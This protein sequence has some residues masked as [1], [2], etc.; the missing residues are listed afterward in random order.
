MVRTLSWRSVARTLFDGGVSSHM[1][2][3]IRSASRWS[4]DFIRQSIADRRCPR[5]T[6]RSAPDGDSVHD[7]QRQRPPARPRAERKRLTARG[8]KSR[9]LPPTCGSSVN[10]CS[11][12]R[13]ARMYRSYTL[14]TSR[15]PASEALLRTTTTCWRSRSSG[16]SP[17][18]CPCSPRSRSSTPFARSIAAYIYAAGAKVFG[19]RVHGDSMIDAGIFRRRLHLR[20]A[21][22]SPRA[23]SEIVVALHRR[24]ADRADYFT[25]EGLRPLRPRSRAISARSSS[26]RS[27]SAHDA[28]R[29]RRRRL[30]PRMHYK[31]SSGR[32]RAWDPFGARD[33]L[34]G[35]RE[36][37]VMSSV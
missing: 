27:T 13:R 25:G 29:R 9:A 28:T 18:G 2:E 30:P 37:L 24:Q 20:A 7:R 19:L 23:A 31:S 34:K 3:P 32:E 10:R 6:R 17:L 21:S 15:R 16:A 5:A 12:A 36:D 8:R 33:I 22:S 1:V 11:A 35:R 26:A 4:L 14:A